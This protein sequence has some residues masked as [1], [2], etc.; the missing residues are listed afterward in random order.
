MKTGPTYAFEWPDEWPSPDPQRDRYREGPQCG[1]VISEVDLVQG[2]DPVEWP[3][4]GGR[5]VTIGDLRKV[6]GGPPTPQ[7][8][9]GR[10]P[11]AGRGCV[12]TPR[13]GVRLSHIR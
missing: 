13:A 9:R 3:S 6:G 10:P 12:S 1:F 7:G 11:G 2:A 8:D 4:G 5:V